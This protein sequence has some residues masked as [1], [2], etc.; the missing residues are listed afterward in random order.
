MTYRPLPPEIADALRT[1]P[2][3][4]ALDAA[5]RASGLSMERIRHRLDTRGVQVSVTTLSYWRRGRSRPERPQSRQAVRLL[6]ELLALPSDSLVSLLG[7][8][9]PRGRWVNRPPANLDAARLWQEYESLPGLLGEMGSTDD[10]LARLAVH[11]RYEID[12]N[13]CE[14]TWTTTMVLRAERERV[15]RCMIITRG[16]D[17]AR[18]LPVLTGV[19]NARPG[20]VRIDGSVPLVV[21]ELLLDRVLGKGETEVVEY[22]YRMPT[23]GAR[24]TECGRGFPV[25]VRLYT[26]EVQF[27]PD[28]VPF[29]SHRCVGTTGGGPLPAVEPVWI[30]ASGRALFSVE[31]PQPGFQA[32]RWEWE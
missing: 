20:R 28:A 11:D 27:H 2:F 9:R 25:P 22:T 26:L 5:V 8:Q 24:T 19:R 32:L 23:V 15:D 12:A 21:A 4:A 7:P 1:G 17:P 29:R 30:S 3:E 14:R 18:E 6:E 13:G 31:D 16:D 10:G